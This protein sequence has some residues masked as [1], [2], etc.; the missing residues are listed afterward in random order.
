MSAATVRPA[1]T[2]TPDPSPQ[3]GGEAL[4]LAERIRAA[5]AARTPLRIVGGDT[6]AFYG[7]RTE[8]EAL[9]LAG[10]R[11]ILDYDPSELVVVA[12]AGT[13]LAEIEA[14]LAGNGQRLAFE[15][16]RLGLGSTIGG[17]V[18]AGLSGPRRPFAGAVRDCVLGATIL[19]GSGETLRFGGQV[20]KN[21]A[22]FDAFRLMAGALGSLGV[23]L[24]VSL[25]VAPNPRR[26]AALAL[27]MESDAARTWLA[28]LMGRPNPLSGAFHDGARLH[29]RLSGGE[30]G[31]DGAVAELGGEA[32]ALSFWDDVRDFRHPALAGDAPL[33]RLSLPQTA[34]I[35]AIGGVVAW[36]WAGGQVWLRSDAAPDK[37]WGAAAAAGGHAT[38]FRGAAAGEEVFQPLAPAIL[39]LHQRLKA[40]FDPAGVL[41]PGRMYGAL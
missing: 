12:R 16:P 19:N 21:V 15:P 24:E 8:G 39:A 18:A 29:L 35:P 27:E 25:R 3:G 20:F 14:A 5:A 1:D 37:V 7:R 34:P 26:E 30:A 40:A 23:I 36:D 41:N 38:R 4:Q 11:G 10:H 31:V 28:Q 33:W 13:P 17:V 6:K 2:P 32:E 22:G 9:N